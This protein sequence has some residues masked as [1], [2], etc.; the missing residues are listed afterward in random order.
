MTKVWKT[1]LAAACALGFRQIQE[2]RRDEEDGQD[3][4]HPVEAEA[5]AALVADDVGDLFRNRRL[6][7]RRRA[8]DRVSD[9]ATSF[10]LASEWSAHG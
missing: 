6:R 5:L 1:S 2:Q 3:V 4:A 7:I 9:S 10:T 8:C